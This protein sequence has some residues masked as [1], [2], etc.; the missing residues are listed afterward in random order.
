[1][2]S[3]GL[4]LLG[5]SQQEL[6]YIERLREADRILVVSHDP[7]GAEVLSAWIQGIG[8]S[9]KCLYLLKGPAEQI[10]K[11][12]LGANLAPFILD[13]F[14]FKDSR[15]CLITS[16]SWKS[17]L[18][19]EAIAFAKKHQIHTV[20]VLDHWTHYRERFLGISLWNHMPSHWLGYL[21]DQVG[22]F[23]HYAEEM[24]LNLGFPCA[25]LIKLKNFYFE[26]VLG[27]VSIAEKSLG[28]NESDALRILWIGEPI[29]ENLQHTFGD[30]LYWG[31][32]EFSALE[33]LPDLLEQA[34]QKVQF[35]CRAHPREKKEKYEPYLKSH[36]N[37]EICSSTEHSLYED[38]GWANWVLGYESMALALA[39]QACKR[40]ISLI[41]ENAKK[42]CSLPYKE[43]ERYG[44]LKAIFEEII[45]RKKGHE[46]PG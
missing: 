16:T 12:R 24:A 43:I 44:N 23:D 13:D 1:M 9:K 27:K 19:R 31:Y 3:Q 21:P 20:T 40:A 35:R 36:A 34:G 42:R 26:D 18:E 25:Q 45:F 33:Q 15:L 46:L 38:I 14:T 8:L 17:D 39:S 29:A 10:F 2:D 32:N 6:S 22:V 7:G 30:V 28:L 5:S 4:E 41:P 37:V 11:H